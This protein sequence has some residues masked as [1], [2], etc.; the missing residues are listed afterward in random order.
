MGGISQYVHSVKGGPL[1]EGVEFDRK[2]GFD[3]SYIYI[4]PGSDLY[5][6]RGRPAAS[7][8]KSAKGSKSCHR[9]NVRNGWKADIRQR[10]RPWNA[11]RAQ[12]F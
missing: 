3:R 2:L 7:F 9:A 12:A 4:D 5:F 8:L 6:S 10:R 1:E 11:A